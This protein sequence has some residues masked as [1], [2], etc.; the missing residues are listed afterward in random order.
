[1]ADFS[2]TPP[3]QPWLSKEVSLRRQENFL[4]QR[5][6]KPKTIDHPNKMV[7]KLLITN[8]VAAPAEMDLDRIQSP[9]INVDSDKQPYVSAFDALIGFSDLDVMG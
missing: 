7:S 3:A 8:E 9:T 1:M 6:P 4:Q 5:Q 2:D